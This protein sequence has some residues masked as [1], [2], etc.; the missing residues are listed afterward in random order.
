M[1]TVSKNFRVKNGL[2]VEGTTATVNGHNILTANNSTDDITE[3]NSKLFF[4]EERAQ[5]AVNSLISAGTHGNITIDYDDEANSLSF[6]VDQGLIPDTDSLEEGTTN[7]YYTN[8]RVRDAVDALISA[9]SHQNISITYDDETNSLSF[10]AE[11][12]VA[13]SDTDDLTEGTTN[14]YYTDSRAR[15]AINA[16][17]GIDYNSAT[18]YIDANL[19]TG[20]GLDG[21]SQIE[22]NRT[23][24]DGWY[25]ANG[26]V[27]DHNDLTSG[28]HGV[29]GDV[30]GTTDTQD[31]S[32]KRVIDT[33]YF[34]DGATVSNEAE[35]AV[36]PTTHQFEIK[37]NL[38]DLDLKTVASGAD[39][40]ITSQS[41]DIILNANGDSY[42]VSATAG[43]EIATVGNIED[44]SDLTTGVHGVSGDVVG[45]SDA[46]T[47]T[48]KTMGDDLLMDGFQISGLGTPDQ[49]DHAAT[50]AY[51]DGIAEGLHIHASVV[52]ATTANINIST[53]LMVGDLID[54]VTLAAT[55]RVLVKNQ[56]T[57]SQNGIYEVQ[58]SGAAIRAADFDTAVEVDGGDFVFVS[59][60]STQADTGWV[61]TSESVVTIGSDPISFTQFSGAGTFLAGNGLELNGNI[62]SIDETITA[63][64]GYVNDEISDLDTDLRAYADQAE[65]DAI[66]SANGY[67]DGE[68]T[69]ALSTAQG[70]ADAAETAA[71]SYTD[72]RET[73][74]TTAYQSYADTAEADAITSAN[75]YTDGRET[76][77]TT[78][79]E[80]YADTAEADAIS[81]AAGDATTKANAAE[82]NANSYT[83]SSINALDTDDI[84]EG[85]SNKYFTDGRAKT[86]AAELLTGAT[87][88]NITITGTG[89]GL[90][91]TAENGVADSDTDDL[92]EGT[93]NLYFT[94]QRAVDALQAVTPVFEEIDVNSIALNVASSVTVA[95]QN[96]TG[97]VYSFDSGTYTS[98]KFLVK[99]DT[100]AHTEVM[101]VLVT[102][103]GSSN[104]AITEYAIVNT[105]GSLADITAVMNG[106][107]VELQATVVN[108]NTVVRAY[109][110]LIV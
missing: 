31:L 62:F 40:N 18:G 101:E 35:V 94:D 46:Q 70:Y 51:V 53:D 77:I 79:Y 109:G 58:S 1:A 22:I 55:N 43:N 99:S 12:G 103:D 85:T 80:S 37:A 2:V 59:G 96:T 32:N 45:T 74:I 93:S 19:G 104:I 89:S 52:A 72:G 69:T 30:V 20:L 67:T 84:E 21:S 107:D 87:L 39:V 7:L 50:K 108:D 24:V 27:S 34:T 29:T 3:G 63:T 86:A 110:T 42:L 81:T 8:E 71:N 75:S 97:T 4:T 11:N 17:T 9:G 10:V 14:L 105:G 100:G 49:A 88:Q 68:I 48:N 102:L 25:E 23:T 26:A 36:K 6:T 76:A 98:A 64:R 61:Q 60:G 41:G 73:A 28:V 47:L 15:S 5:A 57:A 78:A 95:T 33:L 65:T 13:D 44:H 56:D 90:T 54:G 38:G 66:T 91:I 16:G 82:T 83:D 92:D 106:T